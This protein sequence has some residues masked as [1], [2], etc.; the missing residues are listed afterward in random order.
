MAEGDMVYA[1]GKEAWEMAVETK[2]VANKYVSGERYA[3][4]VARYSDVILMCRKM[5]PAEVK[6]DEL[7]IREVIQACYLNISMCFLKT[8]HWGHAF[9]SAHRALR[10]DEEP[11]NP[12]HDVLK[13]EQKAKALFR[14]AQAALQLVDSGGET[15]AAAESGG[16]TSVDVAT[17]ED[18]PR[19]RKPDAAVPLTRLPTLDQLVA[20]LRR[21]AAYAPE[22]AEIRK[23][24]NT[25]KERQK[26]EDKADAKTCKIKGF[27][28]S[29]KG[30]RAI[31]AR[32]GGSTASGGVSGTTGCAGINFSDGVTEN[33]KAN[34]EH[35]EFFDDIVG[36]V[37][38]L[39]EENPEMLAQIKENLRK[40]CEEA[41]AMPDT[42]LRA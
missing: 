36:Q 15:T 10:G 28:T 29:E 9:N 23:L 25:I 18:D 8:E 14:K 12:K 31:S 42:V 41:N 3:D 33:T 35:T 5:V 38:L 13:L 17:D 34:G 30:A 11:A 20:E 32:E 37:N 16:L 22:D 6:K 40:R 4:A 39:R 7:E 1:E 24:I 27:L 2:K 19:V 26:K 21:A